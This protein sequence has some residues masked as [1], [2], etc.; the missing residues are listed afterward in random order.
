MA[1]F[2]PAFG[3][4]FDGR[5]RR[6]PP[7]LPDSTQ[8]TAKRTITN[9]L[10]RHSQLHWF[11]SSDRVVRNKTRHTP[12]RA[13]LWQACRAEDRR[14][15]DT[16]NPDTSRLVRCAGLRASDGD[17]NTD[18][19]VRDRHAELVRQ[20]GP[21]AVVRFE[22]V[23]KKYEQRRWFAAPREVIALEKTTM[24][25][26]GPGPFGLVG[27]S[28]AGK[29]TFLRLLCGEALPS[30]GR[31]SIEAPS[32]P[33]TREVSTP[34]AEGKA[35]PDQG[36]LI[37][38]ADTS[39]QSGDQTS[40]DQPRAGAAPPCGVTYLGRYWTE[41]V[42]IPPSQNVA[43]VLADAFCALNRPEKQPRQE[44]P[45]SKEVDGVDS[46]TENL[47]CVA[48]LEDVRDSRCGDLYRSQLLVLVLCVGVARAVV[49]GQAAGSRGGG[50]ALAA[51]D[52]LVGPVL[53]LD[54]FLEMED[55]RVRRGVEEACAG[56]C[57][58]GVTIVFATHVMEHVDGMVIPSS[59]LSP[60]ARKTPP[61]SINGVSGGGNSFNS[62][63]DGLNRGGNAASGAGNGRVVSFSRGRAGDL[64][65]VEES[66]YVKWKKGEAERR[67]ARQII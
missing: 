44:P 62:G 34:V 20:W 64:S 16:T 25:L 5:R 30:A 46:L 37:P 21:A 32:A 48:G 10:Q 56:L 31:I 35:T 39:A 57:A 54:E 12:P 50:G 65:P 8:G 45:L 11:R 38:G 7:R 63:R 66:T 27:N 6:P 3:S 36:P 59:A 15:L 17:A 47:L 40:D 23:T 61:N 42:T 1:A 60:P 13:L 49:T 43:R 19:A 67:L 52:Q 4:D 58:A 55:P 22:G 14:P 26:R 51:T 9:A 2:V 28:G 29:S 18:G 33:K 24:T 53:C 41:T